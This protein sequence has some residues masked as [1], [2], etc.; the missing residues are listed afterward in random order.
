MDSSFFAG[1]PVGTGGLG[2]LGESAIVRN[3]FNAPDRSHPREKDDSGANA[4]CLSKHPETRHIF[5]QLRSYIPNRWGGTG[6]PRGAKAT[7]TV[8]RTTRRRSLFSALR[9]QSIHFP[10]KRF[11]GRLQSRA[12]GI[13]HDVPVRRNLMH[14]DPNRF[15]QASLHAVS[16]HSLSE[17]SW[18]GEA[19]SR[20]LLLAPRNSQA[21][22]REV[23][24]RNPAPMI[25]RIAEI[26]SS[27]NPSTLREPE[28]SRQ[29]GQL[30]RRSP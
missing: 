17:G 16:H 7:G 5:R 3:L 25:V 2:I 21:K 13:D 15:S 27:Q 20:S 11:H 4:T 6:R 10:S 28:A 9:H 14:T 24:A 19:Q 12:T 29:T 8:Y 26:R 22:G 23:R 1:W 30:S 18:H